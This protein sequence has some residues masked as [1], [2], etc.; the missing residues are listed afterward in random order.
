MKENSIIKFK[1]KQV[2]P[3]EN[4]R[5]LFLM[6]QMIFKEDTCNKLLNK[7]KTQKATF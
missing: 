4:L 7:Y 5:L 2:F 1:I 3:L 6:K